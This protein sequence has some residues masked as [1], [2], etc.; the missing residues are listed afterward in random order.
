MKWAVR[1]QVADELAEAARWYRDIS[2]SLSEAF[3]AEYAAA[4]ARVQEYPRSYP[5]VH[6]PK[7]VRRALLHR[8]PYALFYRLSEEEGV[9]F[10]LRHSAQHPR[11]WRRRS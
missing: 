11:G 4:V 1:P 5:V 10:A 7:R 9:F 8:F 3:F 6:P 2:P